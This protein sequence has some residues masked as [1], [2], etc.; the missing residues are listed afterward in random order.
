VIPTRRVARAG[1]AFAIACSDADTPPGE[2]VGDVSTG[3]SAD[4]T[5]T[6][7]FAWDV[8]GVAFES[9]APA[10]RL[11][12]DLG[13]VWTLSHLAIGTYTAEL[14]PCADDVTL[15]SPVRDGLAFAGHSADPNALTVYVDTVETLPGPVALLPDSPLVTGPI[16]SKAGRYCEVY[17]AARRIRPDWTG[18]ET[19]LDGF[20]VVIEGTWQRDGE[21]PVP[22]RG[23]AIAAAA[24]VTPIRAPSGEP[25]T[26]YGGVQSG[27]V[28][29]TRR[30]ATLMDG[31]DP[32]ELEATD[33]AY[34]A[35]VNL[36]TTATATVDVSLSSR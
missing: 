1:L 5:V 2:G 21:G 7:A 29:V 8:A 30:L 28:A 20:S 11:R 31:L 22:F 36:L 18:F 33:V 4:P 12:S 14:V 35:L 3:G 17:V 9:A 13:I 26:F 15:A 32:A 6:Y 25:F 16:A 27:R 23:D 10:L 19:A 24:L 34:G